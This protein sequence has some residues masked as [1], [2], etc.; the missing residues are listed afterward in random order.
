MIL[1]I[2]A[3]DRPIEELAEET[4]V[5]LLQAWRAQKGDRPVLARAALRPEGLPAAALPHLALL[6]RVRRGDAEDFRIRLVG[7]EIE[8]RRL[9]YVRGALVGDVRPDWYAQHLLDGYRRA[10][11]G[12]QPLYQ[13]V[14]AL[15]PQTQMHYDRLVLPLSA[16]GD[17]ADMLLVASVRSRT[18]MRYMTYEE[19]DGG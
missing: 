2:R 6:E 11:R 18:L 7:G 10:C 19:K 16:A 13:R 12:A 1:P 4:L 14:H 3:E 8:N 17:A 5:L 9:G 15:H